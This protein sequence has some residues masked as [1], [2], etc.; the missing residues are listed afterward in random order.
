MLLT[1]G[2]CKCVSVWVCRVGPG[3]FIRHRWLIDIIFFSTMFCVCV[4]VCVCVFGRWF[5]FF[6]FLFFSLS[7]SLFLLEMEL[8]NGNDS[9]RPLKTTRVGLTLHFLFP[10][11]SFC[12]SLS[13]SLSVRSTVYMETE[14]RCDNGPDCLLMAHLQLDTQ[15]HKV[16]NLPSLRDPS[17]GSFCSGSIHFIYRYI[18]VYNI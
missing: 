12:L 11:L 4:C 9:A 10:L 15:S 17:S 16:A 6:Q 8:F 2:V 14:L 7:L 18:D 3:L 13:L 1:H 5:L